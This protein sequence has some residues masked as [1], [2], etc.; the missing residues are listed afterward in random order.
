MVTNLDT[1]SLGSQRIAIHACLELVGDI[2][3]NTPPSLPNVDAEDALSNGIM[4]SQDA[5]NPPIDCTAK[6][7]VF[8]RY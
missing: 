5:K 4:Q 3:P 8:A 6:E 2:L 1:S 7:D